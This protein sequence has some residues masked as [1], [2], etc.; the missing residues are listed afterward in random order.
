MKTL[1][2]PF[3]E[4]ISNYDREY[5]KLAEDFNLS[6]CE[7]GRKCNDLRKEYLLKAI[8]LVENKEDCQSILK[9]LTEKNVDIRKKVLERMS[10]F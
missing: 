6:D 5:D 4:V 10:Q 2:R 1:L 8:G 7:F 9:K 3:D